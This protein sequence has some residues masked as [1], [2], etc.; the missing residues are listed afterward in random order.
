MHKYW[1]VIDLDWSR[2]GDSE[3]ERRIIMEKQRGFTLIELL[4][5]ISIIALLLSL[6]MPAL[7]HA[8]ELARRA[9]CKANLK[10]LAIAWIMYADDNDGKIVNGR[11]GRNRN[12]SPSGATTGETSDLKV[13]PDGRFEIP[14]VLPIPLNS[15]SEPTIS[16][17]DQEQL[18]KQGS[19]Y[20]NTKNVKSYR[21]P[22]A[23]AKHQRTYSIATSLNGERDPVETLPNKSL[24]CV[25][26]RS[27]VRRPHDRIVFLDEGRVN[28]VSFQVRYTNPGAWIDPPPT[29][30]SGGMTFVFAD[31]HSGYWKWKGMGTV[32][33]GKRRQF[34]YAPG[35]GTVEY[36]QDLRDVRIAVW[37][38]I[39]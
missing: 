33:A 5:V 13:T 12:G 22:G 19:L 28:N 18:I 4:V 32:D 37:G 9:V 7:D 25:K 24:L 35:T 31:G 21:C 1:I 34:N 26:N 17:F 6:L 29:R 11:P 27:L 16:E 30:H 36:R 20:P 39:P 15:A 14:W 38:K 3:K 2:I 10:D 8:R 23:K